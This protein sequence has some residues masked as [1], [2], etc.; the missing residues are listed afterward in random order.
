MFI[1]SPLHMF[2]PMTLF[3]VN[4]STKRKIEPTGPQ[5][6]SPGLDKVLDSV[7]FLCPYI[8]GCSL[9]LNRRTVK[10]LFTFL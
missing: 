5:K 4:P 9:Y 7:P 6:D 3:F 10:Y 8:L 1:T 2:C